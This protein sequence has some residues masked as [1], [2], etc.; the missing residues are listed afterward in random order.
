MTGTVERGSFSAQLV[1]DGQMELLRYP[2]HLN[3]EQMKALAEKNSFAKVI[4]YH[5]AEITADQICS[6]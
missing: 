4:P 6:F 1:E 5:S 2:V 3:L